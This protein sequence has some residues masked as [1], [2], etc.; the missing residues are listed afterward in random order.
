LPKERSVKICGKFFVDV[1]GM[2]NFERAPRQPSFHRDNPARRRRIIEHIFVDLARRR[3]YGHNVDHI[4]CVKAINCHMKTVT[5]KECSAS[6]A[7]RQGQR[8]AFSHIIERTNARRSSIQRRYNENG[9]SEKRENDNHHRSLPI[10][11]DG[12]SSLLCIVYM[13]MT[14]VECR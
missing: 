12:I 3:T 4:M 10:V 2:K 1:C 5:G 7:L 13:A 8:V 11:L 14:K 9:S 6:P